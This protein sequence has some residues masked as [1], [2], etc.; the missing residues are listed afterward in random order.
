MGLL[1]SDIEAVVIELD[2][3]NQP[4]IVGD[5]VSGSVLVTTQKEGVKVQK[6]TLDILGEI[7]IEFE[8]KAKKKKKKSGTSTENLTLKKNITFFKHAIILEG[9]EKELPV[10][11]NKYKFSF[12]LPKDGKSSFQGTYGTVV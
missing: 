12:E 8:K 9:E 6:I 3:A 4:L 11:M 1:S 10:G 7:K 5:V 2:K